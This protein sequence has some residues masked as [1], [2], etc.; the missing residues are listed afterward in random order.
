MANAFLS[1]AYLQPHFWAF[2][3]TEALIGF[4][5]NKGYLIRLYSVYTAGRLKEP[6]SSEMDSF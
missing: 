2:E 3:H 6:P 5:E 1:S 4:R